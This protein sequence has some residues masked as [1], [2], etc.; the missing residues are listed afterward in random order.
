M[1]KKA[2]VVFAAAVFI[3]AGC[4]SCLF[5]PE[6]EKL[7]VVNNACISA[8]MLK[9]KSALYGVEVTNAKQAKEFLNLLINDALVSNAAKERK[10]R[11]GREE[12][13]AELSA[14]APGYDTPEMRKAFE[15]SKTGYGA[16]IKDLKQRVI[17]KKVIEESMKEVIKI[18]E[19]EL[20]DYFWTNI[21]DFRRSHK[22]RARQIVVKEEEK[23]KEL[24]MKLE[25]GAD[26]AQL[27]KQHSVTS[28]AERG[29][30]LDFFAEKDMPAFISRV[31]FKMK[32]GKVSGIVKSPYGWHIFKCEEIKQAETPKFEDVRDEVYE[33]YYEERKDEYL[34]LWMQ[35][36][37]KKAKISVNDENILKIFEEEKK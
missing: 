34:N 22:V 23:A 19:R 25:N 33:R 1:N 32:P 2:A 11:P 14:F 10:I 16:W 24:L 28:E 37:R 3:L 20:K 9:E 26:F 8:G 15:H 31:V 13:S 30:D 27:A 4:G 12:F 29:G 6:E 7:A 21:I 18:D 5:T 17:R 35:E 36:L